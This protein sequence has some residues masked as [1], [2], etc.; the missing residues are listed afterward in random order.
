MRSEIAHPCCGSSASVRRMRRSSVPCG[1]S[2]LLLAID[3]VPCHFDKRQ[4]PHSCRSARGKKMLL[5]SGFRFEKDLVG[6]L[7]RSRG[8]TADTLEFAHK[9]RECFHGFERDRIVERNAH[10]ADRPVARRANKARRGGFLA[11]LRFDRLIP[12]GHA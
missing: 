3:G 2:I 1:S 7:P 5:A 6:G 10:P 12:A 8:L 11:E 4:Y 9:A